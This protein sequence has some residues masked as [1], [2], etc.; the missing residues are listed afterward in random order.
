MSK[1]A[2]KV[3]E[4]QVILGRVFWQPYFQLHFGLKNSSDFKKAVDK[5]DKA[6]VDLRNQI[7]KAEKAGVK[8]APGLKKYAGL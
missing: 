3:F 4:I 5:A 8:T 6:A 1:G 2:G 7:K